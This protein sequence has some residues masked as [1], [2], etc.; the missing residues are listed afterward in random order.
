MANER[1]NAILGQLVKLQVQYF[2]VN[3]EAVDPDEIP[4]VRIVD[5]DGTEILDF[6]DDDVYK[7]KTGLYQIEY[8]VPTDGETGT[9]T[10]TWRSLFG[11]QTLDTTFTFTSV[12]ASTGIEP[13]TGPGKIQLGD[14]VVF[15]FTDEEIYGINIML[16]FLKARLKSDGTKPMRDQFGAFVRDGYGEIMTE[17]C[18]VFDNDILIG[19]LCMSLSEFNM[20]PF[21]TAYTF[22]DQ[23]IQTLFAQIIVEGAGIYA[24]AAQSIIEKGRDFSL[25]DQ[26]ISYQPP[27]LGDFLASHY[28]TWLTSYRERLKYIKNSIRPGVQG[29][30]VGIAST[31]NTNLLR[32][33]HLRARRII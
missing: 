7:I 13:T 27:A 12:D 18:N 5:S 23:T 28:S 14:D 6:T 30:G 3:G 29:F 24:L 10:D 2:D 32:T 17:E 15:N 33:R 31:T 25:S 19:F 8:E 9:W 4:T 21:F 20:T 16:K 11:G 1:D 22:A 26:G